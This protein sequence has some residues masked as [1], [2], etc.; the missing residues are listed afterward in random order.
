MLRLLTRPLALLAIALGLGGAFA[1]CTSLD[2]WQ[3]QAIFNPARDNPRW[4]SEPITGTVEYDVELSNGHRVHM[5][6]VEQPAA[7]ATAPTVLYLHGARW[8]MNGSVFR[9]ARWHELGFNVVAVDY[10]GFGKSTELLPSEESASEDARVAFE[11]LKRRQPDPTLR[12]IYGHSLGG[13]LAIDLAARELNDDPGAVAGVIIESTFTS[14]PDLVRGMKWGW[15]P[16]IGLAVTQPFDSMAKIAQVRVPLLVLH[17]TA[18]GVVPHVMADELYAA[19]GSSEKKLVK[20]EGG[21]H[22]GSSRT[23]GPVY[24]DAVLDFV[25]RVGTTTTVDS[26]R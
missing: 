23:G 5:W 20:I 18:D 22:S 8:N 17:G 26:A 19:A 3:R 21:T 15:V 25:R 1:G 16:G 14:I 6:Y 11:E 13:A 10:R 7:A 24:R 12:Y 2:E 4:F 9:I